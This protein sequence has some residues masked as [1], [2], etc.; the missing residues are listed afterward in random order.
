MQIN[1]QNKS[2]AMWFSGV[3]DKK[4]QE[5]VESSQVHVKKSHEEDSIEVSQESLDILRFMSLLSEDV[6]RKEKVNDIQERIE[7]NR[8][9]I[10]AKDVVAKILEGKRNGA[11]TD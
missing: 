11:N 8:Y 10:S 6:I 5:P 1:N 4:V 9:E 7:G 2:H 3:Q